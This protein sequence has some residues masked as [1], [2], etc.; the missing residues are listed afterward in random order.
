M[1]K[2]ELIKY[3]NSVLHTEQKYLCISRPRRF[4]KS[5]AANM[6]TAYYSKGCD[7]AELFAGLKIADDEDF[8]KHLNQYDT[9]FVNMQEFLSRTESIQEMLAMLKA[10]LLWDLLEVY[11]DFR[12]FDDTD[13]VRTMQDIYQKTKCPFI[14][15]IDEWD[16]VFREYGRVCL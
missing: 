3:T 12:Y 1:D 4:G 6:L 15:I 10:A 16:C 9:I 5:M 2:T 7:S 8:S 13:L 14:L 11:P